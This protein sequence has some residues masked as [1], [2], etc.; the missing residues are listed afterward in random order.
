VT[1]RAE[2]GLTGTARM[3][4]AACPISSMMLLQQRASG[5]ALLKLTEEVDEAAEALIGLRI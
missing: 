1:A 3:P 5:G 4:V 2:I